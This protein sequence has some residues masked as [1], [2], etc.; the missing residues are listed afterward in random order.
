VNA[1]VKALRVGFGGSIK[2][3]LRPYSLDTKLEE[4][5]LQKKLK[6][7]IEEK[8]NLQ[9]KMDDLEARLR[10]VQDKISSTSTGRLVEK[11]HNMK[12]AIV[13]MQ[14]RFAVTKAKVFS[15][16]QEMLRDVVNAADAVC[17]SFF[18]PKVIYLVLTF[19]EQICT[20]CITSACMALNVT[21]FPVVFLD[22]ASM[23]TE[24]AS[25]IPIMKGVRAQENSLFLIGVDFIF[26]SRHVALI[27]DHK[28][29][30]PVIV[31]REA[32]ALGLGM[33]LFE[34]LTG[35]AGKASQIL[36]SRMAD[37]DT[38]QLSPP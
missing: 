5:R 13:S 11:E 35:E 7:Q 28:Q 29:L 15:I 14:K 21:D 2:E 12:M 6:A 24:P 3:S 9:A 17:I 37:A 34:R 36:L 26:Q 27:G 18:F 32:Q 19:F 30:P 38:S 25:L 20:T 22:E 31:S 16:Q 33:S 1:G 23:S 10:D 4:H 8:D